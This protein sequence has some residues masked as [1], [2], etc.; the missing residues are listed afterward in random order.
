MFLRALVGVVFAVFASFAAAPAGAQQ[1]PPEITRG[2]AWLTGQVQADGSL[3]GEGASMALPLQAEAESVATLALLANAPSPLVARVSATRV[4]QAEYLARRALTLYAVR[5]GASAPMADLAVLRNADGGY[6][7]SPGYASDVIDTAFALQALAQADGADAGAA[8]ASIAWLQACANAEGSWGVDGHGSLYATANVLVAAQAW[9]TRLSVGTVSTPAANWLLAQRNANHVYA[10]AFENAIALIALSTQTADAATLQPLADALRSSQQADGSWADDPYVTALAL[11]ALWASTHS[12]VPS[13]TAAVTGKVVDATSGALLGDVTVERTG[14]DHAATATAANGSFL[15]SSLAPGSFGIRLSKLGYATRAFD[16]QVGAGQTLQMG[17]IPLSRASLTATLSGIVRSNGGSA[18]SGAVVSVG[19]A[20]ATTD[21]AGAYSIDALSAGDATIQVVRS[22]YQTVTATATFVAGQHYAFSPTMYPT[23]TTPPTTATLRGT[24]VDAATQAMIA[25]ATVAVGTRTATSGSNGKFE[26][27]GLPPGVFSA[28]VSAAGYQTVTAS[29]T[30][31]VGIDD[32]GTIALGKVPATSTLSGLVSDASSDAPIPGAALVVEGQAVSGVSGPDGRYALGGITGTQL[33]LQVTAN[34]YLSSRLGINLPQPGA[35]TLDVR[36]TPAQASGLSFEEVK[37]SAPVYGPSDKIELEIEVRNAT[38]AAADLVVDADLRDPQGNVVYVFKAN[39]YGPGQFFPNLPVSFPA[40]STTPIEMEW[41]ALRLQAGSYTIYARGS[42]ASGRVITDG[43]TQFSVRSEPSIRGAVTVDP[44]LAQAGTSRPV[45]LA[46]DLANVG[47]E[48]VPAGD[49]ALQVILQNADGGSGAP[50]PT[51]VVTLAS[52]T[53]LA[54]QRGLVRD[55]TGNLYTFSSTSRKL[56]KI[57]AQRAVT[58]LATLPDVQTGLAIDAQDVVWAVSTGKRVTRITPAG[59]TSTLDVASLTASSAIDVEASGALLLTGS[60]TGA[61]TGNVAEQRLVRRAI[62]GSETVLWRNGLAQPVGLAKADAGGFIVANYADNT[63]AKVGANGAVTPFAK[64]LNRP[65]GITRGSG[66]DVFV[67]NSGDGTIAKVGA[68]GVVGTYA[69]GLLQPMDVRFDT[70][71]TLYVSN[72]GND[73]IVAVSPAGQQQVFARGIANAPQGMKYDAAGNLFIANDDG[74]LRR[75]GVD[76]SVQTLASGLVSPR[77]VALDAAGAVFVANL[78]NGTISK[79]TDTGKATFASGLASPVG[80]AVDDQGRIYASES[81]ATRIA[82]FDA[83]GTRVSTTETMLANPSQLRIDAQ[84]R[85]FVANTSFISVIEGGSPRILARSFNTNGMGVD[86][87]NPSLLATRGADLYRIALDGTQT[88]LATLAFTTSDVAVAANGDIVL[89]DYNGKRLYRL[90]AGGVPVLLA[91]LPDNPA[92]LVGDLAG[93]LYVRLNNG[94]LSRVAG[95]GTLTPI[96]FT[97]AESIRGLGIGADGML[98]AWTTANR[99]WSIDPATGAVVRLRDNIGGT[100]SGATRDAVGDLILSYGGNLEV[101]TYDAGGAAIARVDGFAAPGDLLW[102]GTQLRFVDNG[103]RFYAFTPGGNPVK[104]GSFNVTYLAKAGTEILGNSGARIVRW[105]GTAAVDHAGVTGVTPLGVAGRADG[106]FAAASNAN[107]RVVEFNAARAVVAD[108]AGIVKPQGLAFDAQGRLYVAN[109]AANTIARFDA[110]G[111]ATTFATVTNPRYLAFDDSGNLWVSRSGGVSRI[112]PAGIAST[113]G[114]AVNVQ[115]MLLDGAQAYAADSASAQLRKLATTTWSPFATGLS[116]PV[117]VRADGNGTVYVANRTSGTVLAYAGGSL[118]NVAVNLA[119]IN[120]IAVGDAGRLYVGQDGGII[121]EI[122]ADGSVKDLRVSFQLNAAAVRGLATIAGGRFAAVTDTAAYTVDVGQAVAPPAPGTVVYSTHLPMA[123]LGVDETPTHYDFGSWLPPYGGDFR[124]V[125]A[126]DGIAAPATNFL[127]VGPGANATLSALQP[128]LPPGDQTEPMCLNVS[129]ADFTSL[130]RP[131]VASFRKF[132]TTGVWVVAMGADPAGN[133]YFA[134]GNLY[135]TDPDMS[136]YVRRI[137]G[138]IKRI[139]PDGTTSD[140]HPGP[141]YTYGRLPVD[142][143]GNMYVATS[144]TAIIKTSGSGNDAPFATLPERILSMDW[145]P[146][147]SLVVATKTALYRVSQ[148]G[149]IERITNLNRVPYVVQVG[150]GDYAYLQA[151]T[152]TGDGSVLQVDLSTGAVTYVTGNPQTNF[153]TEGPQVAV[154]CAEKLFVVPWSGDAAYWGSLSGEEKR[155][156][157][158]DPRTLSPQSV[159]YGPLYDPTLNDFDFIAYDRFRNQLLVWIDDARYSTTS[160][161][162]QLWR[163]PMTCGAIGVDAHVVTMPGQTLTGM[164][165]APAAVVPKADGRT[166]YVWSL[167]DVSAAGENVCF[168]TQLRDLRLGE[169]RAA[170]DSGFI[171]FHNSFVPEDVQLSLDVPHVHVGN[172][173]DIRVETDRPEYVANATAQITTT[174]SNA[175]P[176]TVSGVLD[177]DVFDAHGARVGAVQLQDVLIPANGSVPVGGSFPIGSL[178]AAGYSVR[179]SLSDGGLELARA[180]T[181]FA[182]LADAAQALARSQ[183]ATD[184]MSYQPTDHVLISSRVLSL[185]S[186]VILDDLTLTVRVF[187]AAGDLRFTQGHPIA[188]LLPGAWKDFVSDQ[189]LVDAEAGIYTAAQDLTDAAG[190]V[191]DTQQTQYQVGSS[192]QT[193]FGL[194]GALSADPVEVDAGHAVQLNGTASNRGNADMPAVPLTLAVIDPLQSSV[195]WSWSTN[196]DIA[197]G[198]SV[199]IVQSWANAAPAGDYVAVL[200]ATIGGEERLLAQTTFR[201]VAPQVHLD[202]TVAVTAHPQLA[203][204]VLTGASVPMPAQQ[205]VRD[206]LT[207]LGYAVT[208]VGTAA[209]FDAALRS[210]TFQFYLLFGD[211][212]ALDATTERLLREAVHRGDGFVV[213]TGSATLSETLAGLA[214]LRAGN[215]LTPIDM[216]NLAIAANAPGGPAHLPVQPPYASRIV[217]PTT[218]SVLA[219]L[220]GRFANTPAMGTLRDAVEA[221]LR[222]DVAYAGTDAGTGGSRL[223]LA[224]VGRIT[225]AGGHDRYTVWRVRNSGDSLRSL[226]LMATS[227]TWTYA[228]TSSPHSDAFIAS[229]VVAGSAE[230]RLAEG[231]AVI[232]AAVAPATPFVDARIV[233]IGANPGAIALWANSATIDYGL[234]W[235]GSQHE[236]HGAIHAN[237]G[238]RFAGAQNLV[239][240]PVHYVTRFDN[241]GSQN[242]FTSTPR[243]VSVQPLPQLIDL[244]DYRPGGAIQSALGAAYLDQSAECAH[245]N[246]WQRNGSHVSLAPGVYWIPCDVKIN[247]AGASGTV[248]LVSTGS[249]ELNGSSANFQ[250]YYHGVQF[251]TSQAGS[252][253]VKLATS[254][255][256]LG[257]LVFAPNGEIQASGSNSLYRCSLVGDTIK[258]AGAKTTIDPRQCAWAAIERR[259]PAV[260]LNAFGAGWAGYSAFDWLGAFDA[261]DASGSGP[262]GQLFHGVL[263]R[264]APDTL[265]LRS[266]AR[267]PLALSV[268]NRGDAFQGALHLD[269]AGDATIVGVPDWLLDFSHANTFETSALVELG[270]GTSTQLGARVSAQAPI[271]VDPLAQSSL[272]IAH[273]SGETLTALAGEL[274]GEPGRD[275][276]LEASLASLRSA[277][278]AL[279]AGDRVAEVGYLLDAAESAGRSTHA[280]ADAYRTRIDW[281]LWRDSR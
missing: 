177:V 77:G 213:G 168:D 93:N 212:P 244:D 124:I 279:A 91:Q 148:A 64:G 84:G 191:L 2:V 6:A 1:A 95:D 86:P 196:S 235:T 27:A 139:A 275:A 204:L 232:Q 130:A 214:G 106:G 153:E 29:G 265:I 257:G 34:G 104:L 65:Q 208:F 280:A 268:Q 58:V 199:P 194:V 94:T 87:F 186:N 98:L 134:P 155:A 224:A 112:T 14:V 179:A 10:N 57:D 181:P 21:T 25:G 162:G 116:T 12:T 123:A 241:S 55:S 166:E 3:S 32:I 9:A 228:F 156:F 138:P 230:H 4:G 60:Y 141:S 7:S 240:G 269:A 39:S 209:E 178:L 238:M 15:L 23:N 76:G 135:A 242:T 69:S 47:N 37:T 45:H 42:D 92:Q 226:V 16:V 273:L 252:G 262:F 70:A 175:N 40:A 74:T 73:T 102:D 277:E 229:P 171:S 263:D 253:A 160:Q 201:V 149:A 88:K 182:V 117:A 82:G 264:A 30:L 131:E 234:E 41:N 11:R 26:I 180:E 222:V 111:V 169:D 147:G 109:F 176:V 267:V 118:T 152:S 220:D 120:A 165:K 66:G 119:A 173:V 276:P 80:V 35:N 251:A 97:F 63:L 205:R 215:A 115:G 83:A 144:P 22:G 61:D 170:V 183:I 211:A 133:I 127:H 68:D 96:T 189:T 28:D 122:A 163:L 17:T 44:P 67:A 219:E 50:P 121:D 195:V 167:R 198:A 108:Y 247:G 54:A 13:T 274:A 246:R 266:G 159:L 207:D 239:D 249:I 256:T 216:A 81:G 56:L 132:S 114:D 254:S 103:G 233:D 261:I 223:A 71:G 145:S 218:A 105:N 89:R 161:E 62:D 79:V 221:Q 225:D 46:A 231:A 236:S 187:D 51:S 190:H 193:G 113:V 210:G 53:P 107:S 136:A 140:F 206:A 126:R 78:S 38:D 151:G 72:Q 36:L 158:V 281:V 154:D 217:E 174:L 203:A 272:A 59:A 237:S 52:G 129:G 137:N 128:L 248:T 243:V 157:T 24:V 19:S 99:V 197:M 100:V 172:L 31:V 90:D 258:L 43:T 33:T 271:A 101:D 142:D 227:G 146:D 5:Q 125:V 255:L 75:R 270:S 49:L 185:S 250:P 18:L 278:T 259:S 260:L 200:K 48:P 20:S 110:N 8:N 202:A 188:Q 164:T 192:G 245:G 150:R 184:R 85:V 143:Q